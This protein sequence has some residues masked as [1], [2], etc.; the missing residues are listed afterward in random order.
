[1][2]VPSRPLPGSGTSSHG[3][4]EGDLYIKYKRLQKQLEFLQVSRAALLSGQSRVV[5]NHGCPW[6]GKG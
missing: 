6:S 3:D 5:V 1:M 4:G 2:A